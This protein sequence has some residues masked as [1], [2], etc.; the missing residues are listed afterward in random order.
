MQEWVYEKLAKNVKEQA[1][2]LAKA[3]LRRKGVK[4]NGTFKNIKRDIINHL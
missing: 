4:E 2:L 1:Q 3:H